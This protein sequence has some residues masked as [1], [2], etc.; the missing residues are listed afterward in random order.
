MIKQIRL[1]PLVNLQSRV[2]LGYEALYAKITDENYPS[3]VE[4]LKTVCEKAQ[5]QHDTDLY[6]NMATQDASSSEFADKFLEIM[7]MLNVKGSR[8]V[9]EIS[10]RT[11]PQALQQVKTTALQLKKYGVRFAL[12]DFGM[13][14]STY[15][16]LSELPI[17]IIKL[18][19]HFV[20]K[21]VKNTKDCEIL[22]STISL[23]HRLGCKVVIEGI[24]KFGNLATALIEGADI[25]QGYLFAYENEVKHEISKPFVSLQDWLIGV[26]PPQSAA[27]YRE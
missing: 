15:H 19:Q 11:K 1:Q 27:Y 23:A 2:I 4:I 26:I 5:I 24:E 13:H 16:Y 17:D 10:E 14:Y 22:R 12:D 9:L 6:I 3:A 21:A 20:G 18:D 8:I 7:H 25:G